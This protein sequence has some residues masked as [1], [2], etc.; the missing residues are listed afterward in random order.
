MSTMGDAEFK[1][2]FCHCILP[3]LISRCPNM[4]TVNSMQLEGASAARAEPKATIN[5]Y[6]VGTSAGTSKVSAL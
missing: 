5:S 2:L 1:L 4:I 6:G 3:T